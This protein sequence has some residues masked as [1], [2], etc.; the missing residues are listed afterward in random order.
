MSFGDEKLKRAQKLYFELGTEGL[1]ERYALSLKKAILEEMEYA[2][3][4]NDTPESIEDIKD[5]IQSNSEKEASAE[6]SFS[7]YDDDEDDE[8]YSYEPHKIF[9]DAFSPDFIKVNM[10]NF[11]EEEHFI[12]FELDIKALKQEVLKRE[13]CSDCSDEIEVESILN[14]S[15]NGQ[16][17]DSFD[18]SYD[19]LK[20]Y[21]KNS[22]FKDDLDKMFI[23]NDN[24][25]D[26]VEKLSNDAAKSMT[27][28][29]RDEV[30]N[31]EDFFEIMGHN[32]D[33]KD[34]KDPNIKASHERADI[35]AF[36]RSAISNSAS[37][38]V[39]GSF[40]KESILKFLDPSQDIYHQL[41]NFLDEYGID[42]E[43]IYEKLNNCAEDLKQN[44]RADYRKLHKYLEEK[45]EDDIISQYKD[46]FE[47]AAETFRNIIDSVIPE[48]ANKLGVEEWKCEDSIFTSSTPAKVIMVLE[49]AMGP[50]QSIDKN[51]G[52]GG[53][54]AI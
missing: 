5:E 34:Q 3:V 13:I 35:A 31:S 52:K 28:E 45:R 15:L 7:N 11:S 23:K 43:K 48:S 33:H 36:F 44:H 20:V 18:R 47:E 49:D 32:P 40:H 46:Y 6:G 38:E 53:G 22:T 26:K 4:F 39:T 27:Q 42:R 9:I 10:G 8:I 29:E 41:S 25:H 17:L 12:S 50:E 21:F 19:E 51:N 37:D 1:E 54:L 14:L 16:L 24:L 2:G 30:L